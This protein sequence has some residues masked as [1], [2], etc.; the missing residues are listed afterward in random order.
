MLLN[1]VLLSRFSFG[2]RNQHKDDFELSQ[3]LLLLLENGRVRLG[4]WR[5]AW[6]M[7]RRKRRQ[8]RKKKKH[9]V[10]RFAKS[11]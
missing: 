6:K 7:R 8:R 11:V 3:N 9:T 1:T 2:K 10:R 4:T 5:L